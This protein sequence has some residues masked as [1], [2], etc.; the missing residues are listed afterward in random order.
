MLINLSQVSKQPI[1]TSVSY[2][3]CLEPNRYIVSS[4]GKCYD[5]SN[6][7]IIDEVYHSS[8]GYDYIPLVM[9]N[10]KTQ[11]FPVDGVVIKS[12]RNIHNN[13]NINNILHKDG[14]SRNNELSNLE[15][16][17]D[18]ET[19]MFINEEGIEQGRYQISN[20]GRIMSYGQIV[21]TNV[22]NSRGYLTVNLHTIYG[23]H[24]RRSYT[25]HRLVAKYFVPGYTEETTDVNHI[26]GIKT[27]NHYRNLEWV[28]HKENMQ[29]AFQLEMVTRAKGEDVVFSKLN[30]DVVETICQQF[31]RFW[32]RSESVY[33]YMKSQGYDVNLKMIQHIKH[34]ECWSH[35]SDK[36]WSSDYLHELELKKIHIICQTLVSAHGD[37][38]TTY[39]Q[40]INIIPDISKRFIQIIKYKEDWVEISDTYFKKG[41]FRTILTSDEIKLCKD[42]L[43]TF[44]M[45]INEVYSYLYPRIPNLNKRKLYKI[46]SKIK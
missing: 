11:L 5:I 21:Q 29:H 32:G 7:H 40:L 28:T 1:W 38:N 25:I 23:Q 30:N 3:D 26:N 43:I 9:R 42:T 36:Y 20:F 16:G 46:K 2:P 35:I 41:D 22:V 15:F 10:G 18:E 12:F 37:V 13:D 4:N 14:D 8:N 27:N 45:D 33:D 6:K 44:N 24:K 34:K 39:N 31:I 17:T 19:W